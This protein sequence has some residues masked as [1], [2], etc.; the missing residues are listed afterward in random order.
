M[1]PE[2]DYAV[3][4]RVRQVWLTHA[5]LLAGAGLRLGLTIAWPP[6][7]AYDDH[8]EPIEV[9]LKRGQIPSAGDCW[10]CYQPP[11]YYLISAAGCIA[12]QGLAGRFGVDQA[13][14]EQVGRRTLQAVSLAAGCATLYLCRSI[15]RR[16]PTL[17]AHEPLALA[18]IAFLPRH[19]YMSAMATND[20]LTYFMA[21]AAVC[22]A[23]RAGAAGWPV[24]GTLFAGAL[25]GAGAL[26]KAY[27]WVSV[28]AILASVWLISLAA[29]RRQTADRPPAGSGRPAAR[30]PLLLLAA[31]ALAVGIWP[32]VRNLWIYDEIHVDN[33][34]LRDTPLRFQPPGSVRQTS[35]FSF[36]LGAL[37]ENPWVHMAHADSFWT[38]LYARLWFDYEGFN[39]TQGRYPA[40]QE[41]WR[42][43]EEAHP[44]WN[45]ARWEMLLNY[46]PDQ[47]PSAFRRTAQVSFVAGLAPTAAV[48]VGALFALRRL[49]R[50]LPTTL[51]VIH[52]GGAWFVPLYQTLRLP[53]FAAMKA[54]FA[55][56]AISSAPVLAGLVLN[57][58][59]AG[60]CRHVMGIVLWLSVLT[61][62]GAD[63][64]FV[65]FQ[66]GLR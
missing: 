57:A 8:Y 21:S 20:A 28:I 41:L 6:E 23:L 45:R 10:Q 58:I 47:V 53:H 56:S 62:A 42:R 60:W 54:A 59:P 17:A 2:G 52:L 31:S 4:M 27:G 9:I 18:L 40:W 43:A 32:T 64:A 38:A 66:F 1:A 48:L 3:A 35:F 16:V 46:R 22:A 65:W 29:R 14:L 15:F 36:R 61:I 34:A 63:C 55:L 13:G 50:E 7:L 39:T 5:I 26:S 12:T 25:A 37:M 11:L 30:S 51:L 33:Y 49:G 19:I 44:V 24:R